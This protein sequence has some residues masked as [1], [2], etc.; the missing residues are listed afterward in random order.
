MEL[1][2]VGCG[3][4]RRRLPRIGAGA[5]HTISRVGRLGVLV[6]TDWVVELTAHNFLTVEVSVNITAVIVLP[7]GVFCLGAG[8]GA[9]AGA[10]AEMGK[11]LGRCA[12]AGAGAREVASAEVFV[13][14]YVCVCGCV[15]VR[16]RVR[17]QCVCGLWRRRGRWAMARA[18]KR[19]VWC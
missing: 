16:V 9:V 7:Q 17:V 6:V 5:S 10:G 4:T 13:H 18:K 11:V 19:G 12:G 15:R 1:S 3:V 14:V 8:V 2:V